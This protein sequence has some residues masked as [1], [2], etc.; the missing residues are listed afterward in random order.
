[1]VAV[2]IWDLSLC[3]FCN[4]DLSLVCIYFKNNFLFSPVSLFDFNS[5]LLLPND[6]ISIQFLG[7]H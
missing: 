6:V 1:M 5:A 7:I 4:L 3:I 2:V